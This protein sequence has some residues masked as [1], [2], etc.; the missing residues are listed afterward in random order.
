[1]RWRSRGGEYT[2]RIKQPSEG[3]RRPDHVRHRAHTGHGSSS[4]PCLQCERLLNE[5]FLC[6]LLR[7]PLL[8]A[9]VN[10][11]NGRAECS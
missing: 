4:L 9:R 11:A 1:M 6:R 5:C 3:L 2:S 8:A 7:T 10:R